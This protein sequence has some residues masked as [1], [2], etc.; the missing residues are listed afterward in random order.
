[1]F[2]VNEMK[3]C[4]LSWY[5]VEYAWLWFMRSQTGVGLLASW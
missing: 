5:Y 4:S 2:T 3:W 1:V